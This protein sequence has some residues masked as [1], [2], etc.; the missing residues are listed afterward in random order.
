MKRTRHI[1]IILGLFLLVTG[2][3]TQRKVRSLHLN[4]AKATL[5]LAQEQDFIPDIRRDMTARRDTFTV[6]DG[7]REI[8]ILVE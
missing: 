8:L 4:A 7:D 6:R 1:L 2:C 5:A 3:G